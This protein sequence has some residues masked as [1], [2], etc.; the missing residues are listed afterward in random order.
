MD[1]NSR[2]L[3]PI[4]CGRTATAP[5]NPPEKS[6]TSEEFDFENN[7]LK[8]E[9]MFIAEYISIYEKQCK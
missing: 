4:V 6:E 1:E 9:V 8:V 5:V 7:V 3:S 2:T